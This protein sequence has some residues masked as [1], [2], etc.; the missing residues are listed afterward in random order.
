MIRIST[1]KKH[2]QG[3]PAFDGSRAQGFLHGANRS[4]LDKLKLVY[5]KSACVTRVSVRLGSNELPTGP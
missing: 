4:T 1:A 2:A 5:L 3:L